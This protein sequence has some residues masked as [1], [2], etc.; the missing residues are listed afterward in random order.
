MNFL[1]INGLH[2]KPNNVVYVMKAWV[3][4]RKRS[5]T[6]NGRMTNIFSKKEPKSEFSL[7]SKKKKL[8]EN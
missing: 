6:I 1:T 4:N 3:I 8:E 5:L 2:Q 7:I